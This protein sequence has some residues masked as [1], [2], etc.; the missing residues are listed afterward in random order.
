[1]GTRPGSSTPQRAAR[2]APL[3]GVLAAVSASRQQGRRLPQS[4]G[5]IGSIE[6]QQTAGG[7]CSYVLLGFAMGAAFNARRSHRRGRHSARSQRCTRYFA[8]EG[9]GDNAVEG[10]D[11]LGSAASEKPGSFRFLLGRACEK[12]AGRVIQSLRGT[13]LSGAATFLEDFFPKAKDAAPRKLPDVVASLKLDA[14]KVAQRER[15]RGLP[16]TVPVVRGAFLAL[17]WALDRL[18]E[19]RPVQKFWVLETIARVPYFSYN[20]VLHLYESVGLWRSPRMREIH[21]AEEHNEM[22]HLLIMEALGGDAAWT[23]RA[24]ATSAAVLY[25]WVVVALFL[26][27]PKLAYNFSV[28]IEEHAYVTYAE[29]VEAN[30]ELLRL[31]PAP[32]V[33][34]NYYTA[35]DLYYF[36]KFQTRRREGMPPRRPP[37]ETLFDVFNNIRDDE[38]EHISTL[39]A[40]EKW[41]SGQGP[42]SELAQLS[43]SASREQWR[44]WAARVNSL[45]ANPLGSAANSVESSIDV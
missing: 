24:L 7:L 26:T 5:N 10:E 34:I 2:E 33:A 45:P 4:S 28:L 39:K 21:N 9:Q 17:S 16:E 29:F 15:E 37:C 40:C 32:P 13:P 35:D 43:T 18:Y 38:Y 19:G 20:S 41:W 1:M 23:D 31:I 3:E 11:G 42:P 44:E 14:D 22:H 30:E 12:E 6:P 27:N 8:E 25:Y 36:D